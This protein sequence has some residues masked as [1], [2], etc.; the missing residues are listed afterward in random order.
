MVRVRASSK[1]GT[2]GTERREYMCKAEKNRAEQTSEMR[3][4]R[5]RG[6]ENAKRH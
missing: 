1:E 4:Y 3:G 5:R 2:I 6:E